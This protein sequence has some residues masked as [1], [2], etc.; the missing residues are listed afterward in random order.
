MYAADPSGRSAGISTS[1]RSWRKTIAHSESYGFK[2]RQNP[3]QPRGAK[4][5]IFAAIPGWQPCAAAERKA[6]A[7]LLSTV[8]FFRPLPGL[9]MGEGAICPR[10]PPWATVFRPLH[11]LAGVG[12]HFHTGCGEST[13]K[14]PRNFSL[15][16]SR[17]LPYFGD[18]SQ[19]QCEIPV[20]SSSGFCAS[21][22]KP[23]W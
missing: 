22:I 4:E 7:P 11:G 14:A 9:G 2:P 17:P 13:L 16:S 10:L 23:N 18:Q 21:K 15:A 3:P 20:A 1:P 19:R 12:R 6:V 5:S 8:L